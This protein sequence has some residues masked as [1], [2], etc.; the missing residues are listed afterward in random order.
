MLNAS[1][2]ERSARAEALPGFGVAQA[3]FIAAPTRGRDLQTTL[4]SRPIKARRD[5][6]AQFLGVKTRAVGSEPL[7]QR[8]LPGSGTNLS[9]A[10]EGMTL[11][12]QGILLRAARRRADERTGEC[13]RAGGPAL[14][15]T[16]HGFPSQNHCRATDDNGGVVYINNVEYERGGNT[17][18]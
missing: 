1:R 18:A 12:A 17:L 2:L 4:A 9:Q 13:G 10:L 7:R 16:R 15:R 6:A 11:S 5:P 14:G 8:A 3:S